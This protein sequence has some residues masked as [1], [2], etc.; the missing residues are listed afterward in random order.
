[1]SGTTGTGPL[2]IAEDPLDGDWHPG[3]WWT[4]TNMG[5]ALPGVLTPLTWSFC[6][7]KL[8]RAVREGFIAIGAASRKLRVQPTDERAWALGIFHGRTAVNVQFLGRL[9]D[10]MPGTSGAAMAEQWFGVIPE[11]FVSRPSRRRYPAVLVRLPRAA[12]T[13]SRASR[14][15]H[16]RTDTWW[17]REVAAA[18]G[19]DLTQARE[20]L[21]FASGVY[22]EVLITHITAQ[23]AAVQPMFESVQKL[24]AAAGMAERTHQLLTGQGEHAEAALLESLWR[25]SRGTQS[26]KGFLD[27]HGCHAPSDGDLASPSWRED[28]TPVLALLRRYRE[29]ADDEGPLELARRRAAE[30]EAA[31]MEL[32]RRTPRSRRPLAR[33]ILHLATRATPLRGIAKEAGQKAI[34]VGRAAARRIGEH[35]EAA[36]SIDDATDVFYLMLPEVRAVVPGTPLQELVAQRRE[37]REAHLRVT[38]PSA[39]RGRPI[40]EATQD[41]IAIE[42]GTIITGTGACAGVAE[43]PVRVVQ[44]PAETNL[45]PG[46]ILVATFTDPGWAALMFVAAGMIVDIGGLQSHAAVTAREL[47]V[48]CIMGTHDAMQRLR[49]GDIVRLDGQTGTVELLRHAAS[50]GATPRR[51]RAEG[52]ACQPPPNG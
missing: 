31:T 46:E 49:T 27:R 16:A 21:A 22:G 37:Q 47:G 52:G 29:L 3:E 44:D 15:A 34:D 7:P 13:A 41:A 32:L 14:D 9:A 23:M 12:L 4:T 40:V 48:P 10:G 18:P 42:P 28:P 51:H 33:L 30:R 8:E 25:V 19:T 36:G 24:A 2:S 20:L 39:W 50:A 1:M 5:E 45:E 6:G 17:R 11:G 43:G 26:L 38:L 35:L